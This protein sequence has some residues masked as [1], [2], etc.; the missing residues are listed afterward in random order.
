M[1]MSCNYVKST[2]KIVNPQGRGLWMNFLINL[3]FPVAPGPG[4]HSAENNVSGE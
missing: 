1:R 3:I 2:K 4:I